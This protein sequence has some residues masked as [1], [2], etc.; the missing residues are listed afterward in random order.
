MNMPNMTF[1]LKFPEYDVTPIALDIVSLPD[2]SAAYMAR[3]DIR[4][5]VDTSEASPL[6]PPLETPEPVKKVNDGEK[7]EVFD[8]QY[9][10]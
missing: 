1:L 4:L 6:R 7:K 8:D 3:E 5:K 9:L 10:L 2:K